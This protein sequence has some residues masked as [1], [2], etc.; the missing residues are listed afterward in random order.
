MVI[1]SKELERYWFSAYSFLT[2]SWNI[3]QLREAA[4]CF[5]IHTENSNQ[6]VLEEVIEKLIKIN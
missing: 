3:W 1:S 5:C 2:V 6:S 4:C